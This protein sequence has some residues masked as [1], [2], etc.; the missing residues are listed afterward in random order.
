M[1][2]TSSVT[3]HPTRP[4]TGRQS[5]RTPTDVQ[6]VIAPLNLYVRP[7]HRSTHPAVHVRRL[8]WADTREAKSLVRCTM[9]HRPRLGCPAVHRKNLLIL[10]TSSSGP[11][12]I[13]KRCFRYIKT[14]LHQPYDSLAIACDWKRQEIRKR[15]YGCC[16]NSQ[17]RTIY[18]KVARRISTCLFFLRSACDFF[19]DRTAT[20]VLRIRTAAVRT[21]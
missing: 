9:G 13:S 6:P 12:G 10:R 14:C 17:R 11:F 5:P 15:S 8:Q 4:R 2:D 1:C 16:T 7:I 3:L 21:T 20:T 19:L 18:R